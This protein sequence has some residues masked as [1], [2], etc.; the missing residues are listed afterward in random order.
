MDKVKE[1]LAK[2]SLNGDDINYLIANKESLSQSD[3]ERLGLVPATPI[4]VVEEPIV[5]KPRPT[6]EAQVAAL[7]REEQLNP[8]PK[9]RGRPA[10]IIS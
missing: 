9:K 5:E 10:K 3:L 8:P 4:V 2:E 7:I 6:G 1:I